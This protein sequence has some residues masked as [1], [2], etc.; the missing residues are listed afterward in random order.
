MYVNIYNMYFHE[1]TGDVL[2][3]CDCVF[4]YIYTCIHHTC[5]KFCV[6]S[7]IYVLDN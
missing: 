6:Q 4:I 7:F 1:D 2:H 3:T 5:P